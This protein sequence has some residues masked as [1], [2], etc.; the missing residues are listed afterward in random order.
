[1]TIKEITVSVRYVKNLGN[2]STA[3]LEASATA[4]LDEG[5]N[6]KEAYDKLWEEVGS[7]VNDKLK[8]FKPTTDQKSPF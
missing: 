4:C 6:H 8:L 7:Q 5:E 3:T 1:M 2:Y